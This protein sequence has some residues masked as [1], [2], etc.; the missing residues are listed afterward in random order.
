MRQREIV[1]L[2]GDLITLCIDVK[3]EKKQKW[4]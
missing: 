2:K 3:E 1:Y 4:S